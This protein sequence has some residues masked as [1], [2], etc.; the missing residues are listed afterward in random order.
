MPKY[1]VNP[2]T[3]NP[4]VCRAQKN[5]PFGGEADHYSTREEAREAYEKSQQLKDDHVEALQKVYDNL[6]AASWEMSRDHN[7][8]FSRREWTAINSRLASA[9]ETLERAK[10]EQASRGS[11]KFVPPRGESPSEVNK[12]IAEDDFP[13]IDPSAS[14]ERPLS[15]D[16]KLAALAV[17]VEEQTTLGNFKLWERV[18]SIPRSFP[19]RSGGSIEQPHFSGTIEEFSSNGLARVDRDNGLGDYWIDPDDLTKLPAAPMPP[20]KEVEAGYRQSVQ[21][22][23]LAVQS[24]DGSI[25]SKVILRREIAKVQKAR[26]KFR[27]S[28]IEN[29]PQVV[30][31]GETLHLMWEEN[32]TPE[33]NARKRDWGIQD[34]VYREAAAKKFEEAYPDPLG[35][36]D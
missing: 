28:Y 1:H 29:D 7:A 8:N 4:G 33:G 36:T 19:Q 25:D 34:Q 17:A 5:C 14:M 24:L 20:L 31:S 32:D 26:A 15:K 21:W 35:A 10:A 2:A 6:L 30:S 23:K 11:V 16:E 12:P 22:M 27:Q 18:E 3:G 13:L 9:K